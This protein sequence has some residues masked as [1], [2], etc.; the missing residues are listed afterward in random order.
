VRRAFAGLLG[1]AF[2]LGCSPMYDWRESRPEGSSV[3]LMFPCRPAS[4]ARRVMLGGTSVEMTMFACSAGDTVFAL[5]FAEL[6]DPA[7]VGGALDELSR[8]VRENVRASEAAASQP[9][10]VPG[11]TPNERA[12]QWRV[13]G[14]LP[15]G[16]AVQERAA[17]FSHGTRVYQA[18]MLGATLDAQAQE[19]FFGALRVG[20]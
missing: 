7:L 4:H 17:V 15:D 9:A 14:R 19:T 16:R 11:M 3:R 12:L 1:A 20:S 18:T 10:A 5:A 13:S 2:V 6:R 8:S